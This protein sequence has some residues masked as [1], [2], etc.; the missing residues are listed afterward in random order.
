MIFANS[1]TI[2]T[3]VLRG[4]REQKQAGS[5][6]STSGASWQQEVNGKIVGVRNSEMIASSVNSMS[7][8][9]WKKSKQCEQWKE[10]TPVRAPTSHYLILFKVIYNY[11]M[12]RFWPGPVL[13][14]VCARRLSVMHS[15]NGSGENSCQIFLVH[16]NS[17][18]M[19]QCGVISCR[20]NLQSHTTSPVSVCRLYMYTFRLLS[21]FN[22]GTYITN[23]E[24]ITG[25]SSR[26]VY[27]NDFASNLIMLKGNAPLNVQ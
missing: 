7:S 13:L 16:P 2:W 27:L 22:C 1:L 25:T 11:C 15:L 24:R 4:S 8:E 21:R 26:V 19:S 5:S 9:Q 20:T 17:H 6:S 23:Y 12:I 14:L 10:L 3:F 18:Q